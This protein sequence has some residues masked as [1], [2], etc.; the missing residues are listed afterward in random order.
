MG[1]LRG[2]AVGM[3]ASLAAARMAAIRARMIA[4]RMLAASAMGTM[5]VRP[6]LA[7]AY[8]PRDDSKP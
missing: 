5:A 7:G 8:G 6:S 4:A 1:A 2:T 3:I